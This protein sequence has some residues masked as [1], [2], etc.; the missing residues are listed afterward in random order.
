MTMKNDDL[1]DLLAFRMAMGTL[2]HIPHGPSWDED[3]ADMNYLHQEW[4]EGRLNLL[5]FCQ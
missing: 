2:F 1:L 5:A 4:R 3:R